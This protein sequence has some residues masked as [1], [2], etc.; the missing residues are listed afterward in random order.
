MANRIYRYCGLTKA[1]AATTGPSFEIPSQVN[2]VSLRYQ[3]MNVAWLVRLAASRTSANEMLDFHTR[4]V[5]SARNFERIAADNYY[6]LRSCA[7]VAWLSALIP[8]ATVL[9]KYHAYDPLTKQQ[10]RS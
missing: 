7:N 3:D 1:C 5:A 8:A 6:A 10:G 4:E 2:A 9:C